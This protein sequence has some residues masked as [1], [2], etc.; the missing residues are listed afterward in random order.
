MKI[1]SVDLGRKMY[2][3]VDCWLL[4]DVMCDAESGINTFLFHTIQLSPTHRLLGT[5]HRLGTK[6]QVG[7]ELTID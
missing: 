5:T 1:Y 6:K 7:N 3:F 4:T 2:L